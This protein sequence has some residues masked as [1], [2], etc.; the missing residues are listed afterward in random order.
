MRRDTQGVL[1]LLVGVALLDAGLS[2]TYLR[3][4]QAGLRPLLVVGGAAFLGLAGVTLWQALRPYLTAPVRENASPARPTLRVR[5]PRLAVKAAAPR[6]GRSTRH[7]P[8]VG[9]TSAQQSQ[10]TAPASAPPAV[11]RRLGALRA[12]A[13]YALHEGHRSEEMEAVVLGVADVPALTATT[14]A[15]PV[16]QPR[17]PVATSRVP[18]AARPA[19]RR[20]SPAR[21]PSVRN[22]TQAPPGGAR[23]PSPGPLRMAPTVRI[24]DDDVDG[25]GS[26]EPGPDAEPLTAEEDEHLSGR[27][28]WLL[29]VPVLAVLLVAPPALGVD[30]AVRSGTVPPAPSGTTIPAGDEPL[31]LTLAEYAALAIAGDGASLTGRRV[32]LTG[33]VIAGPTGEPYLTRIALGCCAAGGR[34]VKIG[35]TGDVPP[36]LPAGTWLEVAGQHIPHVE[37]DPVNRQPIPYVQVTSVRLIPAPDQPYE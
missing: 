25:R 2:G 24:T 32:V 12:Q 1:L 14:V 9:A 10:T 29:L 16:L 4:A 33:F 15:L 37:Q 30:H 21:V 7:A 17:R 19:F 13:S 34:P 3:Y 5:L 31:R 6:A 35:L 23:A 20:T 18:L 26:A 8:D 27:P 22:G 11:D 36:E 28:G